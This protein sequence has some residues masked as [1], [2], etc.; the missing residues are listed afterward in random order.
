MT[1]QQTI[2]IKAA[3]GNLMVSGFQG[4]Y[5]FEK[6][7]D[8]GTFYELDLLETLGEN[9]SNF[10]GAFVD[11]GANLGNH[12]LYFAFVLGRYVIA[13]EPERTNF[14]L[15]KGNVQANQL[16]ESVETHNIALGEQAGFVTLTQS[17]EGN[18]GTF[19]AT[20]SKS[21]I[22]CNTLDET[23]N[24]RKVAA[25]KVDV[26]GSELA[27]LKGAKQT[28]AESSP[29]LFVES[30]S[31]ET[32]TEIA[33]LLEPLG[34]VCIA[35]SG[36]SD[37]YLWVN[38]KVH[39]DVVHRIA[40]RINV[41]TTRK[42]SRV[43]DEL[44]ARQ[45]EAQ[46]ALKA[47]QTKVKDISD[48]SIEIGENGL[49]SL[50][51]IME[52]Q[53]VVESL[54]E[55]SNRLTGVND[56]LDLLKTRAELLGERVAQ[57][58]EANAMIVRDAQG[59]VAEQSAKFEHVLSELR[60]DIEEW[61]AKAGSET[62][63]LEAR[64]EEIRALSASGTSRELASLERNLKQ[65]IKDLSSSLSEE[66]LKINEAHRREYL[67]G[68]DSLAEVSNQ[69]K[70]S[71]RLSSELGQGVKDELSVLK[72]KLVEQ[73][74]NFNNKIAQILT[75]VE[76][77]D[78]RMTFYENSS[79][80]AVNRLSDHMKEIKE[81][82]KQMLLGSKGGPVGDRCLTFPESVYNELAQHEWLSSDSVS[83]EEKF[84]RLLIA[85][86]KMAQRLEALAP[87]RW[88]SESMMNALAR[89][90]DIPQ[91]SEAEEQLPVFKPVAE[92]VREMPAP[93]L[94][95]RPKRDPVRVGIASMSGREDGLRQVVEILSPQADEV[96]VY[97]NDM[98]VVPDIL[99]HL[100]NVRYF[101]GPD[102]GD[103]GKFKFLEGFEGYYLTCDDDIAYAPFHV[104]S[105][106]DGIE[107]YGRKAV[108]GWHGSIFKDNFEE[109]YNPK[110]RQVLSFKF[111]RG[112]DTPVHL[113][114]TGVCGFHTSTVDV[115]FDD[116]LYPNMA[117]VFMAIN[118]K[119]QNVPMV[120]LAHGKDW[121]TPIEVGPSI[122]SVSL[123]KDE[124][125]GGLDV[126]AKATELVKKEM[127]W[128]ILETPQI[129]ARK[130]LTLAFI[131]RTN[132]ERW[133]K[134]G[135]LKS[136]H[137]T[138]DMLERFNVSTLLEDIETGDP[139]NLS[140]NEADIVLIYVG[141]PERPD[142]KDV[143]RLI[144]HHAKSG[145]HVVVNLSY[146]GVPSRT[147]YIVQKMKK[148]RESVGSR[149]WLMVFTEAM[150]SSSDLEEI[151]DWL[152]VIPKTIS[153]P[154]EPVANFSNSEG[155]FLG[156]IA[157]L[158]NS[159]LLGRPAA[160]WIS[161]IKRA[162]PEVPL[163]A[164]QQYK[165][166]EKVDLGIDEVWPFLT[167]DEF[168]NRI[169]TVRLMVSLV[170]FATFEMVPLEVASLGV[171]VVYPEMPQ[172]LGEYLG[173]SGF[174]VRSPEQLERVLPVI[175]SDPIVWRSLSQA[176]IERAWSSELNRLAGQ[177][178]LRIIDIVERN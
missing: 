148:L 139:K 47:L 120:V 69:V 12:T 93:G 67:R 171:P 159:S 92:N 95:G 37:N 30:H 19:R 84:A 90:L 29:L 151:R 131:G 97:L 57:S 133:K 80:Q 147:N 160:D 144:A 3:P 99:P 15:L 49:V 20:S 22:P 68:C 108:V 174:A 24:G 100:P 50:D 143:E 74:D 157:K 161:A 172:S 60:R 145:R 86:E 44:L 73:E 168:A 122:S 163:Y 45:L 27:V 71:A 56:Q 104:Q 41:E 78:Q 178:Y 114:G 149:I 59:H 63:S 66:F 158:S 62:K 17:I 14:S 175:Y 25:I 35:I 52:T 115:S 18:Y 70:S 127:P 142:F 79:S 119:K 34:Y 31:S 103:R 55:K 155:I 91:S 96:C 156:D 5:I 87:N 129:Y 169:G 98:E 134:G 152:V 33:R 9:S 51:A 125:C 137:L 112:K 43:H 83:I 75:N 26:E 40:A 132:K 109:F 48:K 13:A 46:R 85:Y 164:V 7:K 124:D 107:R 123:K 76:G 32:K 23:V 138:R 11:A 81:N 101:L 105:I 58:Y 10:D 111:L 36:M 110:S 121:A 165:P 173:L 53:A 167:G 150:L 141:D 170:Q 16:E 39:G 88:N 118:A 42:G 146:N 4:E 61:L 116:F 89:Q 38:E 6:I 130:P 135:I 94:V 72:T 136:A 154:D 8:S 64:M 1:T 153:L 140:G 2:T 28:I 77:I 176:G 82:L 177:T 65:E 128:R 21:G 126:A 162:L 113:L 106:I 54:H 117:D 102:T 166:K